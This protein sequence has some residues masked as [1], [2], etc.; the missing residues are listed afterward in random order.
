M[1][2]IIAQT[3]LIVEE[4]KRLT[5]RIKDHKKK[6]AQLT[7]AGTSQAKWY[8]RKDVSKKTGETVETFYLLHPM[9]NGKR[10]KEYVGRNDYEIKKAQDRIDRYKL[11]CEYTKTLIALETRKSQIEEYLTA[12]FRLSCTEHL[13]KFDDNL[14]ERK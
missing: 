14:D 5:Q 2:K 4:T 11:R 1:D 6:I 12:A 13:I 8:A 7:A 9:N 10:K 3:S